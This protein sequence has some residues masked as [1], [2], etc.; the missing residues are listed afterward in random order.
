MV[1]LAQLSEGIWTGDWI[2]LGNRVM[3]ER[4]VRAGGPTILS[5]AR[6]YRRKNTRSLLRAFAGLLPTH[7]DAELR[8]VGEGP[9]LP[10]LRSLAGEL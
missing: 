7:P 1:T 6:Q 10:A 3:A 9:E 8:I 4:S 2:D 5:V